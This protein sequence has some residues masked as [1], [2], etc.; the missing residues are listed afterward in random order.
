MA[1]PFGRAFL[2]YSKAPGQHVSSIY[3]HKAQKNTQGRIE[4]KLEI[5]AMSQ[6]GNIF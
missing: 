3:C 1:L 5:F 2:F 4:E 6:Q